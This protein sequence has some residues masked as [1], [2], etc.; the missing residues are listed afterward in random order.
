MTEAHATDTQEVQD[1]RALLRDAAARYIERDYSFEQ[2]RAFAK[3]AQAINDAQWSAFAEMGWLALG[4]PEECGGF[5]D[6]QDAAIVAEALGRAQALEPWLGQ[7]G[8]CQPLLSR[9]HAGGDLRAG[10]L[11]RTMTDGS[12]RVALAAWEPQGRHDAFDIQ[13]TAQALGQDRWQLDGH[14]TLVLGGATAQILLIVARE[15][16]SAR[17]LDG[18]TLFALPANTPGLQCHGLPTYDGR[19]SAD[20][21]LHEVIVPGSARLG[22][23]AALWPMLEAAIDQ[24][25]ALACIEAVGTMDRVLVLTKDYLQQRRQFG[26]PLIA[27]QVLRH[28]LVDLYVA[29]E[30][31]RAIALSAIESLNDSPA[32]RRRAV[33]LAKAFVSPAAR[34]CGEEG[35]QLHGAIGMTIDTEVGQAAR[36]LSGLANLLGDEA[37]HLE[38][39]AQRA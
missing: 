39:L 36:R 31:S 12:Q 3:A 26:R 30:Q 15:S 18:L 2:R 1:E 24:A 29:I 21:R 35:V 20:L 16:G 25:T 5:G 6:T 22:A 14:K 13:T 11:L 34:K 28:R 4:A 17:D 32:A 19:H 37:W 8:L 33:S 27:N 23:P 9:I 10:E 38:R 7:V